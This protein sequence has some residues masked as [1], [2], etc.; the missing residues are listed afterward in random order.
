M[1]NPHKLPLK[2]F[3]HT[4]IYIYICVKISRISECHE[5]KL[6]QYF[7]PL[8]MAKSLSQFIRIRDLSGRIGGKG[9]GGD[10]TMKRGKD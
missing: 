5:F 6:I 7:H 8:E 2:L 9:G 1:Y 3:S 4:H 10:D